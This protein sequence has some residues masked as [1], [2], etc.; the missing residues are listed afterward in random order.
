[1][2]ARRRL[3]T[4]TAA[5]LA[6]ALARPAVAAPVK[7]DR[8]IVVKSARRL[9]LMRGSQVLQSYPIRLG[10]NPV[11]PKVFELDGRT[12]EGEYVIDRRT[13]NTRY[14]LALHISYPGRAN[15]ERAAK[16]H[17][18]AGGAIFIH[19]TPGS[20]PRFERDWTDGCIAVSNRAIDEIWDA[21]DNGTPIEIRP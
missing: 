21:V 11:G 18:P 3:V 1:M 17:L 20:G 4:I 6:Y 8:I 16:Y 2:I 7:A 14:H 15:V 9:D 19:G 13:R 5:G 10:A 12:P